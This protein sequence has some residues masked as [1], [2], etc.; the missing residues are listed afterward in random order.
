MPEQY[1][2]RFG[3]DPDVVWQKEF[4]D[5]FVWIDKWKSKDEFDGRY[6]EIEKTLTEA[7]K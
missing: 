3:V 1:A 2:M 6:R 4:D 5:V 7:A